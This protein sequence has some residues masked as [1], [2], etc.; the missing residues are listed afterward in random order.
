VFI[1][2][3]YLPLKEVYDSEEE[4]VYLDELSVNMDSE[5]DVHDVV[6]LQFV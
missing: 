5:D 3:C 1:V 4:E 6:S 2:L